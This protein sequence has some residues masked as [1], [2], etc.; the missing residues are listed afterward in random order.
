MALEELS[1]SILFVQLDRFDDRPK[2]KLRPILE[3]L[4]DSRTETNEGSGEKGIKVS[5]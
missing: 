5:G 1:I 2:K 4:E 3:C